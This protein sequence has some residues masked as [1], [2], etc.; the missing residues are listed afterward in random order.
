[1]K[2]ILL[3]LSLASAAVIGHAEIVVKDAWVRAT[4]PQQKATGAFMQIQ[5]SRD[6]SLVE[7][8]SGA[9]GIAEVH[10]MKMENNVMKMRALSQ[11][12]IEA[13]KTVELKPGSFHIMLMDLKTQAK[14]GE[15]LPLTLIFEGKDKKRE[16]IE[17]KAVIKGMSTTEGKM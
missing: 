15:T 5:S 14:A 12:N 7:V 11:L 10:E 4:V 8:Q 17:V 1:M 3:M 13:G 6:V 2:K 16:M 9:A